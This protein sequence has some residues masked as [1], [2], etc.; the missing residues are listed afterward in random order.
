MFHK[1][2]GG[3]SRILEGRLRIKGYVWYVTIRL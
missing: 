2:F 3:N 1:S